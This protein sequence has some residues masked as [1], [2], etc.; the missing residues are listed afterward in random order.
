MPATRVFI[1]FAEEAPLRER[2]ADSDRQHGAQRLRRRCEPGGRTTAR[3]RH[4][5][6][7]TLY[8]LTTGQIAEGPVTSTAGNTVLPQAD[9]PALNTAP[10]YLPVIPFTFGC[11]VAGTRILTDTGKIPVETLRIGQSVVVVRQDGNRALRPIRWIGHRTDRRHTACRSHARLSDPHPRPCL[12]AERTAARSAGFAR[13]CDLR[14]RPADPG[15]P[16][17]QRRDHPAR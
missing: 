17:A 1:S 9:E 10:P 5:T 12:R 13:P 4:H 3:R 16:V 14:R 15:A 11:F 8:G 2:H 6:G 7:N